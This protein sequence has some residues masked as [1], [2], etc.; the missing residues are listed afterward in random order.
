MTEISTAET[1]L[2]GGMLAH[3]PNHERF[4][5]LVLKFPSFINVREL[6]EAVVAYEVLKYH[7]HKSKTIGMGWPYCENG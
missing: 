1:C 5:A 4:K 6:F 7:I 3:S 2:F